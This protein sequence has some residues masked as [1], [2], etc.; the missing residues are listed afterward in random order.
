V[1]G[2]T[3]AELLE[4]LVRVGVPRPQAEREAKRQTIYAPT[5]PPPPRTTPPP[6]PRESTLVLPWS[7]VLSDN[8]RHGLV[9]DRIRLTARYRKALDAATTLIRQQWRRDPITVRVELLVVLH[10]PD[11]RRRDIGNTAKLICDSLQH[12]GAFLDDAQI[13][14]LIVERAPPST[15]HPRAVLTV[16]PLPPP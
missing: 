5:P 14:R 7:L 8:A 16:R 12:G 6:P 1:S 10:P 4:A 13:D 15:D 2:L 9:R 11:K 3:Y